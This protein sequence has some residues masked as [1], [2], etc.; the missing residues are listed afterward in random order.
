LQRET[1]TIPVLFAAVSD[2]IGSGFAKSLANPEENI[3]GFMFIEAS[4]ANVARS[5]RP[6][7]MS[8]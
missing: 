5:D 6:D 2:P 7:T 8:D 3:T 1:S 4:L